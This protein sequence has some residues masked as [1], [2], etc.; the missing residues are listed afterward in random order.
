MRIS[1]QEFR[2][3]LNRY[4]NNT[5][6]AKEREMLD[7]FFD[8]YKPSSGDDALQED[9]VLAN[10]ILHD[11]QARLNLDAGLRRRKIVA[12]WV[13]LA[14][15]IG[16]F[17]I[18]F[19]FIDKLTS[20]STDSVSAVASIE[21]KTARGEKLLT[22]LP[23]GT[24]VRL[25]SE[26]KITYPADFNTQSRNVTLNGEAYFDVVS[27]PK[28]FIVQTSTMKTQVLGTSFNIKSRGGDDVEV[29]LVEGSLKVESKSGASALLKPSEQAVMKHANGEM[30]T[31]TINVLRY[32]SW[33]D[34]ILF[35]ERT[36]LKE[37]VETLERWYNVK[38]VILNPAI[39]G[40]AIT[41][42]YQDEPLGNV[43][44]S[45]QFLL[46]LQITLVEE[47]RYTIDGE[48]CK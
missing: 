29:T 7:S 25:N 12:L 43:L 34:N 35:F 41:A 44:S 42:K 22:Q 11:I 9:K 23:D 4:L 48:R 13:P 1:E 21:Q 5:A 19:L 36:S 8:S 32:V 26:S 47:G 27:S 2:E 24:R 30:A 45:F 17:V 6:S 40:C 46:N 18:A 39:E 33:K 31:R 37:A 38:I 16:L 3:L 10:E 28:P 15:V 20:R 14:A